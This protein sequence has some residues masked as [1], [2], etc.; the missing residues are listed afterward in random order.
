MK[1]T[2]AHIDFMKSAI[3][4]KVATSKDALA[5]ARECLQILIDRE[6]RAQKLVPPSDPRQ[7]ALQLVTVGP[8]AHRWRNRRNG[9]G[10]RQKYPTEMVIEARTIYLA[11][12]KLPKADRWTYQDI[13]DA[14]NAKFK[15][16][17]HWVTIRDWVQY[18][19][20]ASR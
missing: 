12:E 18:Y 16:A 1:T 4:S 2:Q 11:T 5:L 3:Q 13:A 10:K 19:Y 17:V 9:T 6:R 7:M 14:I 20:R 8:T 15:T